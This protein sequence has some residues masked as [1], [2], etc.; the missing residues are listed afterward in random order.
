MNKLANF[1][2]KN[3]ILICIALAF[4]VVIGLSIYSGYRQAKKDREK[5][6]MYNNL[7]D[8]LK[9]FK[10]KNG[11]LV[12]KI[13]VL[14]SSNSKY[15]LDLKTKDSTVLKLQELVKT[16]KKKLNNPG[17]TAIVIERETKIDTFIKKEVEFVEIQGK[18]YLK[19][20]LKNKWI[21]NIYERRGDSSIWN[22]QTRDDLSIAIVEDK[23]RKYAEVT[24]HNP[25]S[26]TKN[27]RLWQFSESE[28]KKK[29]WGI[30]IQAGYGISASPG[31]KVSPYI[32]VGISW[33]P[34]TF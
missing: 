21:T 9:T 25:Y 24:N 3:V 20:T 12:N 7:Q 33:N 34:I 16:Y 1:L 15:F 28:K 11:Q 30:G 10:N 22:L 14:E 18:I 13:S 2:S 5:V 32:G 4:L 27:L 6:E 17:G 31:I 23:G 8:S 26:N 19:D 29:N